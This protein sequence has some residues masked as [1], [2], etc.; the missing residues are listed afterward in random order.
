[1][2]YSNPKLLDIGCGGGDHMRWLTNENIDSL[3]L[4]G[5]DKSSAMLEQTKKRIGN[6]ENQPRFIQ[7]NV[8][9]DDIFER[10]SFS[11]ITCYYFTIYYLNSKQL[12]KNIRKWLKPKGWF[13]VHVVDMEK[14]DPILDAASPFR[15][16]DPQ[17]YVK[18]RITE[19]TVHF[20]K[21]IYKANFKLKKNKALFEEIFEFK[22]TPKIRTQTHTLKTIDVQK[23]IDDMGIQGLEL[24][25]ATALDGKGYR[26]QNILYFQKS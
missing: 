26:E 16:I 5:I 23:F 2:D 17:K 19:S 10:S 7:K 13:V 22:D 11:H 15:G 9:N 14:F 20:K 3:E 24:K 21:F 8:D 12:M 4:T 25:K 18:T 1:L 6:V